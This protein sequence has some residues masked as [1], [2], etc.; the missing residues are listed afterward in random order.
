M[1]GGAIDEP[2]DF[3]A[4]YLKT[5]VF[6]QLDDL[7]ESL[8]V[9]STSPEMAGFE[10]ERFPSLKGLLKRFWII[11][12]ENP[13][14]QKQ[15][16][17]QN[18]ALMEKLGTDLL[19]QGLKFEP[20]TCKSSDG[21]WVEQSFAVPRQDHLKN[22]EVENLILALAGKYLQ[23]SVFSFYGNTMKILPVLRTDIKGQ[24]RYFVYVPKQNH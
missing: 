15:T 16:P 21:L 5:N 17:A 19:G 14:S 3:A 18:A 8:T 13:L 6:F 10:H 22:E 11:T 20:V 9:L 7:F 23:N 4:L 1:S 24:A 12:A 2:S